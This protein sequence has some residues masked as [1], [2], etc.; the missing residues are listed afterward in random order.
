[1]KIA[2]LHPANTHSSSPFKNFDP[3]CAPDRHLPEHEYQ[4]FYILKSTAVQQIIEISSGGFDVAINLC[5]G[6]WDEDRPGIEVVHALER[7]GMAFTGASSGFYDPSR[8]AMK[9]ACHS[10]GVK[11]PAYILA[12]KIDDA[13]KALRLRFPLIVKHPHGYSSVGLTPG[14]LVNNADGLVRQVSRM[15]ENY[16]AALI[17]EFIEGREFTVLVAEPRDDREEAWVLDPIEFIFPDGQ[18]FKHF[19]LKWKDFDA[20]KTRPVLERP[21]AERL[22]KVAALTFASL[23]GSGYG[24]CDLRVDLQGEIH[25]LEINPNCSVFYP[26]GYYGSADL[27]LENDP[28]G[29]RGFLEHLLA[30]AIRRRERAQRVWEL[31]FVPNRGFGLVAVRAL[32]SGEVVEPFEGRKHFLVSRRHVERHWTGL[33][34]QWF[35]QYAWPL[36]ANVYVVWSDNPDEWCPIN[37]ACDPNT[38]LDGLDLVARRTIA[39]GDELTVDYATFCGPGMA[40]FECN[41]GAPECR[42]VILGSDHLLPVVR[43]RYDRHVSDFVLSAWRNTSPDSWPQYEIVQNSFGLGLAA[44]QTWRAADLIAEFRPG[45]R[46]SQPT[47]WSLQFSEEEHAEPLP[48][49]LGYINHSCS[50]NAQFDIDGGLLRALCDI[51]PGDELTVFYPATEWDMAGDFDCQC[52]KP[53]CLGF[54]R[55]AAHMPIDS[56]ERQVLSGA[57]HELVRRNLQRR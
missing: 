30:F 42:Q 27:I 54:I 15:I 17:E 36:T 48:F 4:D 53:D 41:C 25:L 43:E 32:K 5:D 52:G 10:V 7:L 44:R 28:A 39:A 46:L 11:F 26:D 49:E 37:H 50:P 55:G 13:G 40:T 2:I 31:Q 47:R 18:N 6:A 56:L 33:R 19:D 38:W 9:M 8:E 45:P 21:F 16:G 1:M 34:R 23:N 22:R 12:R 35:E 14:S 24:R 51:E 3:E 20:M 57:I 29:H